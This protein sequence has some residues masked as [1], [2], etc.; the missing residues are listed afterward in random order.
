MRKRIIIPCVILLAICFL[1]VWST[2]QHKVEPSNTPATVASNS[3]AQQIQNKAIN[4]QSFPIATNSL[5]VAAATNAPARGRQ[6]LTP[7]EIYH[8]YDPWRTPINFYGRVID[9]SSGPVAGANI[10]FGWTDLSPP[11]G[12]SQATTTS[13][14]NGLFALEGKT[15]LHL[16]V[17]VNK[18]GYYSSKSNLDSFF[19]AEH[20]GNNFVPDAGNPVI[21]LLRKKGTGENLIGVKQNY[22]VARDGT[23]LGI[24]LTTGKTTGSSG[25][26]VVQC[27]TDDQGKAS[28][29][30]YDWHC[31]VTIPGG[32]VVPTDEE[33]PFQAPENGYVPT[34]GIA[35]PADRPD[36]TSDV[37]LKFYYRLADGRY[38]RMTFSMIAG[39][40]HFCMIDSV[41]NPSGSRNLE[42]Q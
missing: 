32:G 8:E 10:S 20:N 28:G 27:W 15:G 11:Q 9:L 25:D 4:S 19:Y 16:S 17:S 24:D 35:M 21:F 22:R 36:W 30:K 2:N 7:E 39:G 1:L 26:F 23:P 34:N 42:P 5:R 38:G 14:A 18:E 33:F 12:H 31:V 37:D 40:Q 13:D 6:P 29:Q 41:L 3:A